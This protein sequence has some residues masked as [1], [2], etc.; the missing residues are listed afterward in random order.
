MI[1]IFFVEVV[2]ILTLE[3][4]WYINFRILWMGR[5]LSSA[6]LTGISPFIPFYMESLGTND[7]QSLLLWSGLALAAPALSYALMT[8]LWGALSDRWSRKWMVVRALFGLAISMLLMGIA[9]TPFQFFLCRLAQGAFGGIS[10]A[11]SAFIGAEAPKEKQGSALG[12]IE[13]ASA[14]GLLAGPFLGGIL[15]EIWGCRPLLLIMGFLTACCALLAILM[16][17]ESTITKKEVTTAPKNPIW[18][19]FVTL[20]QNRILRSFILAGILIK[21]V[22]FATFTIFTPYVKQLVQSSSAMWI[23]IMLAATYLGE[24]IGA[25][26]WGRQNDQR[27]I[28]FNFIL[29]S[30]LCSCCILAQAFSPHIG[31]LLVIRFLQG[32]FFS[33]LLQTVILY[34][35]RTSNTDSRGAHIGATNS[36]LMVGQISGPFIGSF[37][38][39]QIGLPWVFSVMGIILALVPIIIWQSSFHSH[40]KLSSSLFRLKVRR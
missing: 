15:V 14:M 13:N 1:F 25:P 2:I 36:I 22:D 29:A 38:A 31:L 16:M 7:P 11:S 3:N 33:A 18:K 17:R 10:D 27:P 30:L 23:G 19:S 34:V 35:I 6:G 32:F 28:E 9:Q 37:I 21:M 40:F 26:W 39:S 12:R 20:F 24:V 5:F 8:P 4:H